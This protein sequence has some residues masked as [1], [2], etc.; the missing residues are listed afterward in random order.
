MLFSIFDVLRIFDA[1]QILFYKFLLKWGK[2]EEDF[3][4]SIFLE[5][6]KYYFAFESRLICFFLKWSY[7]QRCFDVAQRCENRCWKGRRCFEVA[8]R[9]SIQRSNTQRCFNV[10]ECCRFQHWRTQRCFNV[11]LTLCD[12]VTSYQTKRIVE[13]TLKCL[14]GCF[15]KENPWLG[16][17]L[18]KVENITQVIL[19]RPLSYLQEKFFCPQKLFRGVIS[20]SVIYIFTRKICQNTS[21]L[22][23]VFFCIRTEL[24]SLPLH[25]KTRLREYSYSDIFSTVKPSL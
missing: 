20:I 3:E 5:S 8:Q 1:L 7:S 10:V 24:T 6:Q 2:I 18:H 15:C 9:C 19:I 17:P 22:W 21:F 13:P 16:L 25:W 11:D 12:V 4:S 14:L 23:S